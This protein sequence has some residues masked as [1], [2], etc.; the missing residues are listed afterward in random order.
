MCF[1]GVHDSCTSTYKSNNMK[2]LGSCPH[3]C[4]YDIGLKFCD[5]KITMKMCTSDV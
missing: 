5:D 1:Q 3:I 4:I 2:G